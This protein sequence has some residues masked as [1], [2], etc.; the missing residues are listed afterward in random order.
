MAQIAVV[1]D[2]DVEV[3]ELDLAIGVDACDKQLKEICDAWSV[4]YTPV[5]YYRSV[6]GLR[7]EAGFQIANIKR[8][9]DAPGA[10]AYHDALLGL[11][12]SRILW[13][14]P[15][16]AIVSL[17]HEDGEEGV[18]P[19]CDRYAPYDDR[20]DQAIEI[21]LAADTTIPLLS[22]E[23][24][25]IADLVGEDDFWVYSC[26]DGHVMP[27]LAGDVR[28]TARDADVV[29]VMLDDG[30]SVTCT[31]DHRF[32]RRDGSF[33]RACELQEGDSMMPLYRRLHPIDDRDGNE[34]EQVKEPYDGEWKF[35][36]RIV[37]PDC[38]PGCVR[39]HVDFNRFNNSPDNLEVMGW[40]KHQEIHA[41]HVVEATRAGREKM[42]RDGTHPFFRPRTPEQR[43]QAS[44]HMI[45]YN[46]SDEHRRA[47]AIV[48]PKNL[49]MMRNNPDAV[50]RM[51]VINRAKMVALNATPEHKRMLWD[52]TWGNP[53]WL[54]RTRE[55]AKTMRQSPSAQEKLRVFFSSSESIRRFSNQGIKNMH[56][57]WHEKRGIS[58]PGC[59]YCSSSNHKVISVTSVGKADVYD[60]TVDG[61]RNFA[62]GAGIFAHNCDRVE[63]D[64]YAVEGT[65]GTVTRDVPVS[66][67]LY[68][69]AFDPKGKYPF[70]KMGILKTWNGMTSGGY[71]ILRSK[72]TG[73]T[74]NVYARRRA[75]PR[76]VPAS[77]M[78]NGNIMRRLGRPESRLMRRLRA[79]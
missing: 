45:K 56:V 19:L 32:M 77:P 15:E 58:K 74:S 3:D 8:T 61:R 40:R 72:A 22:G 79:G 21:C 64:T 53:E 5:V 1:A 12:F 29:Q 62:I 66:N 70:D 54:Q 9:L 11:V 17:S 28:L 73:D 68:P 27:G 63:G 44:E 43:K 59:S 65:I 34:Y 52:R 33:A 6:D 7:P 51:R 71:V 35:T 14:N 25:Q 75:M 16:D 31:A 13:T 49:L 39:H 46:R 60:L 37:E 36:H 41:V 18:D 76:V 55:R 24:V 2:S 30:N 69:S 23:E 4:S 48:G 42:L 38:P 50:A 57:R 67:W 78:S 26:V 20:D 10:L 47:A